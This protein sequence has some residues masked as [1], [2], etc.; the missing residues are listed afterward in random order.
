MNQFELNYLGEVRKALLSHEPLKALMM[1][2]E[3]LNN[4]PEVKQ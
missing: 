1:L 3:L 4:I 2:N